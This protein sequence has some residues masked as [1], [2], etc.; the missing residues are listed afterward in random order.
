[1]KLY[2]V[3]VVAVTACGF[4]SYEWFLRAANTLNTDVAVYNASSI[5]NQYWQYKSGQSKWPMPGQIFGYGDS[6]YIGT[7]DEVGGGRCDCFTFTRSS[8]IVIE[9]DSSGAFAR[10]QGP[11][12]SDWQN[13]K[14]GQPR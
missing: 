5:L 8:E 11:D 9:L 12:S 10:L 7:A 3:A 4:A 1:M 2:L 6:R 14:P 13:Q